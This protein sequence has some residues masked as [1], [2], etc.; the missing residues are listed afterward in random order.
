MIAR[1]SGSWKRFMRSS[2]LVKGSASGLGAPVAPWLAYVIG[3]PLRWARAGSRRLV[4]GRARGF[5]GG[6]LALQLLRRQPDD[7]LVLMGVGGMGRCVEPLESDPAGEHVRLPSLV[8]GLARVE[9]GHHLAGEQL[10]TRADVFVRGA[11]RLVQQDHL[12]DVGGLEFA[13]LSAN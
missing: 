3:A 9:L 12:V 4:G 8:L 6:H 2:D 10:E 5:F 13:E 1:A 7:V 11:S